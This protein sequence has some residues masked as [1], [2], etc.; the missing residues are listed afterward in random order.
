[1]PTPPS[2]PMK[3][4]DDVIDEFLE[5]A[6]QERTDEKLIELSQLE[7]GL[8]RIKELDLKGSAVTEAGLG[9]LGVFSRLKRLDLTGCQ[10]SNLALKSLPDCKALEV[11]ILTDTPIDNGGLIYLSR[12][13]RLYDLDLSG[14]AITDAGFVTLNGLSS[15][16]RLRLD[17][18][19]RLQGREFDR[20]VEDGG[21]AKLRFL[22]VNETRFPVQGLQSIQKLKQ[23]EVFEGKNSGMND[24]SLIPIGKCTGL[25]VLRLDGTAVTALGMKKL[26]KLD[27]LEELTLRDCSGIAD[28]AFNFLKTNKSLRILDV[29]NTVCSEAAVQLLSARFLTDTDIIY[30]NTTY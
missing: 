9:A 10:I 19:P 29:T 7:D 4:A 25:R 1:M 23:L 30:N 26:A 20:L 2:P 22:A 15:L 14:T 5:S 28:I 24:L 17:R 21:F 6:P 12:L 16:E 11:L 27:V 3:T 8:N 18:N 13:D